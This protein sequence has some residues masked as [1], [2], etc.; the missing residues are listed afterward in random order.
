MVL[1]SNTVEVTVTA[2]VTGTGPVITIISESVSGNTMTL[3]LNWAGGTDGYAPTPPVINW[4]DG[5]AA[6][7]IHNG[8]ISHAYAAIGSYNVVIT[9]TDTAGLTTSVSLN[10][11]IISPSIQQAAEQVLA[12]MTEAQLET[13]LEAHGL[14]PGVGFDFGPPI[15]TA[16]QQIAAMSNSAITGALI[17]FTGTLGNPTQ[18]SMVNAE[19]VVGISVFTSGSLGVTL[20]INT[21][22]GATQGTPTVGYTPPLSDVMFSIWTV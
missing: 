2:P 9:D 3:E 16:L 20:Y 18:I 5:S 10:A 17:N 21:A 1:N 6:Q 15:Y 11:D 13:L 7:T 22:Q 12:S 19:G 4:G 14:G 8:I